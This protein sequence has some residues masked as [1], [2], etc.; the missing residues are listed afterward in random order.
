MVPHTES[1]QAQDSWASIPQVGLL[2]HSDW[3]LSQQGLQL[4]ENWE[5]SRK[6]RPVMS[7]VPVLSCVLSQV[8]YS[9]KAPRPKYPSK[10]RKGGP[11]DRPL[12]P[13][14]Q[15]PSGSQEGPQHY[16]AI[17]LTFLQAPKLP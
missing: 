14:A 12:S 17:I 2:P 10:I 1:R 8:G 15:M 7:S 3:D 4:P 16:L 13:G 9:R 6:R 5:S 11:G